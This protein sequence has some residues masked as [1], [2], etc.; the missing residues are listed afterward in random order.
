MVRE[1]RKFGAL[2]AVVFVA[3]GVGPVLHQGDLRLWALGLAALFALAALAAPG[4]LKHPY[5][6]W[7]GFGHILHMVI[8]P[9]IM[10]AVFL[11]A[12]LPFGLAMRAFGKD[13]LRLKKSGSTT[14]HWIDRTPPGPA[15][16]SMKQSF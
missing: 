12:F 7:M 16:N 11:T 6:L 15:A 14:S 4:S 10:G 2:F 8:S 5:R 9:I 1:Y 13:S 3:I